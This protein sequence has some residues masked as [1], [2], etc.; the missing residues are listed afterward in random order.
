MPGPDGVIDSAG[1]YA[2]R[3]LTLLEY[4]NTVRDLLGVT[5]QTTT[6]GASPPIRC[7]RAASAAARHRHL[8]R[9]AAVPGRVDKLAEAATADLGKLMPA[10]CAAP[11]AGAEEGCIDQVRRGVRAAR[12]PPAADRRRD[13]GLPACSRK[14]RGPDVG[15]PFAEAVH[16]VL[17]AILQSPEFLYRWEL[18]GEPDQ[19][20]RPRSSSSPTRSPRGCPTS[21]GPPCPTT[22]CSR[23]AKAG[24]LDT[25]R[26]IAAQ[27]GA[28]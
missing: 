19:G 26:Q 4:Q 24:G 6:G 10:G 1:P 5:L 18:G 8:G 28:C 9:L 17:L 7:C 22:S 27:A 21:C 12:L 2:L 14:L 16:D 20:R 11:A 3:R 13:S 25:A 23:A 15:A